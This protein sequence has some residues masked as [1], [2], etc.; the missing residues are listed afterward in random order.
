LFFSNFAQK[1]IIVNNKQRV[2]HIIASSLNSQLIA[3]IFV[4]NRSH[5]IANIKQAVHVRKGL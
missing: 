3:I 2:C 1:K 4:I 5:I